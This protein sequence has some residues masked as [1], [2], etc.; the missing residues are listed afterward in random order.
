MN[1]CEFTGCENPTITER[2]GT[3]ICYGCLDTLT[4]CAKWQCEKRVKQGYGFCVD[5]P[6]LV[7]HGLIP[8]EVE[9]PECGKKGAGTISDTSWYCYDERGY[10]GCGHLFDPY[11]VANVEKE[12]RW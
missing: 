1:Q 3:A 12:P 10:T 5:H 6:P 4:T 7:D 2:K 9:C 11:E 8:N